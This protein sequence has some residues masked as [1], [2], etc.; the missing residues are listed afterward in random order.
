[1]ISDISSKYSSSVHF[2][3]YHVSGEWSMM[4]AWKKMKE[5]GSNSFPTYAYDAGYFLT[6][7]SS[8]NE[9]GET[10]IAGERPVHRVTLALAKQARGRILSFEGSIKEEE[11]KPFNGTVRV[12]AVENG[13]SAAGYTWNSVFRAT[14]LTRNVTLAGNQYALFSGTWNI[15]GEV[16][17]VNIELIAVAFDWKDRT[18]FDS[19]RGESGP[20]V[21]QSV[22][23]KDSGT[24]LP[25]F[26]SALPVAGI[27]MMS[28]LLVLIARPSKLRR[29]EQDAS[30]A[31]QIHMPN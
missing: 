9:H 16:N 14:L 13:L 27:T 18:P 3:K 24:V 5:Y 12:T 26:S 19:A 15:S 6:S 28:T 1:M 22:S 29:V 10:E 11:E 7:G 31:Q 21:V 8:L 25:E 17:P 20:Y 4:E 2:V 30:S 23:D